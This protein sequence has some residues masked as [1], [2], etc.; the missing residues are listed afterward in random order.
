MPETAYTHANT[1]RGRHFVLY[2]GEDVEGTVTW[3]KTCIFSES[4][5]L[6]FT[7]NINTT[8]ISRGCDTPGATPVEIKDVTSTGMSLS[9]S[10]FYR[11]WAAY[12][13]LRAM[14]ESVEPVLVKLEHYDAINGGAQGDLIGTEIG[15]AHFILNSIDMPTDAPAALNATLEFVGM[16]TLADAA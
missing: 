14:H 1:E 3:T 5:Q 8:A 15:P 6:S 7:K 11:G 16:T 4:K 9:G 12:E 2:F 10:G 13:E